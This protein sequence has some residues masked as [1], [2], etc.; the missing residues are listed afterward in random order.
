MPYPESKKGIELGLVPKVETLSKSIRGHS[1][2]RDSCKR[3][4]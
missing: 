4:T 1:S 2:D 3:P